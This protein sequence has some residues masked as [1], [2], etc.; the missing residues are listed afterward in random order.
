M[1]HQQIYVSLTKLSQELRHYIRETFGVFPMVQLIDMS[2]LST[3]QPF[4]DVVAA[5][6]IAYQFNLE[7]QRGFIMIPRALSHWIVEELIGIPVSR[8]ESLLHDSCIESVVSDVFLKESMITDPQLIDANTIWVHP[9]FDRFLHM[10]M[11]V[12][13]SNVDKYEIAFFMPIGEDDA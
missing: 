10:S 8:N 6:P 5:R 3:N 12:I 13:K 1:T 7:Q 11:S 9:T 2:D 4:L